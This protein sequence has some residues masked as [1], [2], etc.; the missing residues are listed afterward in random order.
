MKHSFEYIIIYATPAGK[1]AGI[2]KSMQKEELD[3]LLQKL[4]TD[5]CIVEK[6]EIIRRSQSHCL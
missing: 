6:V 3:T 2:Y 1:R 5:G 4:Q